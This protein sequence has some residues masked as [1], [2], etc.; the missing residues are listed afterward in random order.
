MAIRHGAIIVF[1][2]EISKE[3]ADKVLAALLKHEL[4]DAAWSSTVESFDD[5][6]EGPVWYIP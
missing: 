1:K 4:L 3:E 5:T 6:V 2:P